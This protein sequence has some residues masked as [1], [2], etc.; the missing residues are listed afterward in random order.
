MRSISTMS[1]HPTFPGAQLQT[2][3]TRIFIGGN[4]SLPYS[5]SLSPFV[6]INSGQ[7]YNLTT[8]Q[9]N[10]TDSIFNDRPWFATSNA[11]AVCSSRASFSTTDPSLG[12]VPVNN[13]TGPAD[14]TLNL[15]LSK[16]IGFGPETKG[17][18]GGGDRGYGGPHMHG[19]GLGPGGL[20]GAGGN[21]PFG[22]R[23]GSS[24]RYNLTFSISAR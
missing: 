11:N 16:T 15:R 4:F 14:A 5:F 6:I 1:M 12:L 22:G 13:C 21:N 9:D 2:R 23:S 3:P 17:R 18:S 8:G 19:G 7:P 10:N 20:S 24:R